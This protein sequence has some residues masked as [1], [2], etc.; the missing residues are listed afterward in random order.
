MHLIRASALHSFMTDAKSKKPEDLSTGALTACYKLAREFIY[1]YTPEVSSKEMEKGTVCED[2]AIQ[3]YNQVFFTN[4]IKN[5]VRLNDKHFTGEA[6]IVLSSR[7]VDTKCSWSIGSFP[8]T[9]ERATAAAIESGYDWQA[10]TYM[11]LYDLPKWD[12][13]YCLVNTPEKLRRYE[14]ESMH[15]FD[16]LPDE[17]KITVVSFKRDL[18]LEKLMVIKAKAA[19]KQIEAYIEMIT[20]DHE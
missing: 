19:Q 20:K 10:R 14:S 9:V 5:T 3:L 8:A 2:E 17:L 4:A 6:D 1:Q 7:G 11:R 12:I 16:H 15:V 18:D 13:A